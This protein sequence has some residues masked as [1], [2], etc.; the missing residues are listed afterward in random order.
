M[1]SQDKRQQL[2]SSLSLELKTRII[3]WVVKL[4]HPMSLSEIAVF[5]CQHS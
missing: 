3:Y 1:A 2:V 5:D 4:N